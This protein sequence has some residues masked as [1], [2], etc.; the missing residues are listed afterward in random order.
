MPPS[1]TNASPG[2][3]D[4]MGRQAISGKRRWHVRVY[5]LSAIVVCLSLSGVVRRR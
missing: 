4:G 2:T 3:G 5:G 1:R